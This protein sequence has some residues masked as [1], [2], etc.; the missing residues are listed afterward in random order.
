[1]K[2]CYRKC[3]KTYKRTPEVI[4]RVNKKR[5]RI[6]IRNWQIRLR[7][8]K[9]LLGRIEKKKWYQKAKIKGRKWN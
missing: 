8:E 6:E 5:A 1:M 4:I 2:R 7:K 9:N 3:R